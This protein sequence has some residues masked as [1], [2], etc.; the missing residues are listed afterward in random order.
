LSS[1]TTTTS[2][3]AQRQLLGPNCSA[4]ICH[5]HYSVVKEQWTGTSYRHPLPST[6]LYH[7]T[8]A[9]A[10]KK[11]PKIRPINPAGRGSR[12]WFSAEQG[13]RLRGTADGCTRPS[14]E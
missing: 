8:S 9:H 12:L 13:A 2:L 14:D 5:F 6:Y 1:L 3:L 7:K 4:T 10:T 11:I